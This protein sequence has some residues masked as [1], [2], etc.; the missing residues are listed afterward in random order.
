MAWLLRHKSDTGTRDLTGVAN[1]LVSGAVRFQSKGG[2]N[3]LDLGDCVFEIGTTGHQI[4]DS[5]AH[6]L[7]FAPPLG[8]TSGKGWVTDTNTSN[9]YRITLS[10]LGN[11]TMYGA[12]SGRVLNGM[13]MWPMNKAMPSESQWPGVAA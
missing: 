5:G 4:L 3:Y 6:L 2:W 1:G 11:P 9:A 7:P 13:V 12:P 8:G 10:R